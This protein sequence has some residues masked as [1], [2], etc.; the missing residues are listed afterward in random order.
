MNFLEEKRSEIDAR[1]KELK[2]LHEEYLTLQK[3]RAA[4]QGVDRPRR[5]AS[6]RKG[7][8]GRPRGSG[9]TSKKAIAAIRK[10]PEGITVTELAREL[11]MRHPNYLYRVLPQLEAQGAVRKDGTR[12]HA[13]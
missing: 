2:P 12:W 7:R 11:K 5:A 9:G 10:S 1:L 8:R 3:A 4:L 6:P 13:V